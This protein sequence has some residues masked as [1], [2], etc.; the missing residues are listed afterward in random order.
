MQTIIITIKK[1]PSPNCVTFVCTFSEGISEY[2]PNTTKVVAPNDSLIISCSSTI[3][4]I[5]WYLNGTAVNNWQRDDGFKFISY[6]GAHNQT[7]R[8]PATQHNNTQV[9]CFEGGKR[10][11]VTV[12]IIAGWYIMLIY[13]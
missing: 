13:G 7:V 3:G 2:W 11:G 9:E 4:D 12:L 6:D 8:L 10:I 1:V 5:T